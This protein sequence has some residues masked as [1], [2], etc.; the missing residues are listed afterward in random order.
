V[1]NKHAPRLVVVDKQCS[2]CGE[3]KAATL[4]PRN[5]RRPDGLASQCKHCKN[6]DYKKKN[7]G[8]VR[9]HNAARKQRK[10]NAMPSW[11]D[12]EEIAKFYEKA[13]RLSVE[14]GIQHHVDH[15]IP[16]Q[17]KDIC[18]LHVPWNLRVITWRENLQKG[19]RWCAV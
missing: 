2:S 4:F 11:A 15:I 16:I 8:R 13:A 1:R 19:D 6:V 17:G 5:P 7:A 14:T 9:A 10:R 3:T 12:R 18:G